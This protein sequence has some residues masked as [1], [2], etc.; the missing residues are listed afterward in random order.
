MPAVLSKSNLISFDELVSGS[1]GVRFTH[2]NGIPYMSIRDIIMVIC[3][4]DNNQAGEVWR[5]WPESN[6]NELQA[7]CLSYKFPGRGQSEQPVITLKGA[8]KL[9]MR[10][11]GDIAKDF[12]SEACDIL[13]RFLAGDA[14]LIA[15]INT[16][17]NATE[18]I[19]ELARASLPASDLMV[20]GRLDAIERALTS[21]LVV[22]RTERD[23]ERLLRHQADGRLGSE[24]REAN[25]NVREQAEFYRKQAE[26]AT[27]QVSE[28]HAAMLKLVDKLT[29]ERS[30]SPI[31]P[32]TG[33]ALD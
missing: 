4:K 17:A 24:V 14:S 33:Q 23:H 16:N 19:N 28:C 2:V 15:E 31:R 7:S 22:V 32:I 18:P 1:S 27:A 6:K 9:I 26:R 3:G 8:L 29:R 5:R 25:K 13:T 11:P 12:R 21:E 10:L 20:M 30:F